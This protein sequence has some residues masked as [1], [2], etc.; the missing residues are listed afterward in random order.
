MEIRPMKRLVPLVLAAC[1]ALAALV[2]APALAGK[3]YETTTSILAG[4]DG[5]EGKL[6][7]PK[8]ACLGNRLVRGTIFAGGP[9]LPLGNVHS[10]G[11]GHWSYGGGTE[12]LPPHYEVEAYVAAKSLGSGSTCEA[13]RVKKVF[14]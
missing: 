13:R 6:S 5:I 7:S 12:G 8:A 9:P 11:S 14:R 3:S 4:K 10:D 2:A 1:L